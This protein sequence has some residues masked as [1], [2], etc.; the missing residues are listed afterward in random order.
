MK[1]AEAEGVEEMLNKYVASEFMIGETTGKQ[2][3]LWL[4][5]PLNVKL[6]MKGSLYQK[7]IFQ[8]WT[9]SRLKCYI[10]KINILEIYIH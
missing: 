1:K 4:E 9:E 6:L 8:I 7:D 10:W 3:V 5:K 2:A